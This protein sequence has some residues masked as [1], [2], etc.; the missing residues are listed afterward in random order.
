MKNWIIGISFVVIAGL[1]VGVAL[2][3]KKIKKL[4]TGK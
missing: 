4:K 2:Q 3:A 1:L